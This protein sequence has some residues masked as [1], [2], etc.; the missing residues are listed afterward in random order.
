MNFKDKIELIL[1]SKAISQ[2]DF[3][4]MIGVNHIVFNRNL[5]AN[6]LTGDLIKAIGLNTDVDLNWL[7]KNEKVDFVNEP[8]TNYEVGPIARINKVMEILNEL[9]EEIKSKKDT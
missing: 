4:D 7:V 2:K 6:N 9:K 5:Q 1:K 8:S 3:A